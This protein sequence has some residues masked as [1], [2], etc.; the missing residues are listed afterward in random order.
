[1]KKICFITPTSQQII[2]F[3]KSL[4]LKLQKE[5]HCI[6]AITFDEEHREQ[7]EDL[8]VELH[9]VQAA[10]RSI[11][12]FQTLSLKNSITKIIKQVSPDI[13]FTFMVKPNTFGVLAAHEAGIEN[14]YSMVE[15]A[16]DVFI[17]NGL[18]WKLIRKIVCYLYKKAF[19]YSKKV[20]FLNNDDK[21][22][23]I[24]RKLVKEEQCEIIHGVGIDFDRFQ[25]KPILQFNTFIMLSRLLKTKGVYEYCKAA[26]KVKQKYT[27]TTFYL[28][29]SEEDIKVKDLQEYIDDNSIVYLGKLK[30]VIPFLEKSTVNVLPSYREGFGLVNAEAAA[31]GRPSITCDTN[32]TRDTII[33]EVTG[34]LVKVASVDAIVEKMIFFIENPEQAVIMGQNARKFAEANFDISLVNKKIIQIAI[35]D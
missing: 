13:V 22:E 26:R 20:F 15:G 17:K 16:G 31:I 25:Y 24:E 18:K 23:F 11:N 12:P 19:K 33:D 14:I 7:V 34:F 32:G 28:A 3:R 4:I 30:D 6:S 5:G 10:N 21:A 35:N 1:M 2:G 9:C 29:G 8:D 27:D